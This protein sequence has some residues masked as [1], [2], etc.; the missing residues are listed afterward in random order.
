MGDPPTVLVVEDD[1]GLVELYREWLAGDYELR[2]ATDGATALELVDDAVDV[3][4]IDRQLSDI[5]GDEVLYAIRDRGYDCRTAMVTAVDPDF[6]VV[7]TELDDYLSEPVSETELC[8]TV[9]SLLAL[10]EY[11]DLRLELSTKRVRHSVLRAEKRRGELDDSE[12]FEQLE[13]EIARLERQLS[14]IE[15]EHPDYRPLFERVR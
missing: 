14:D 9:D 3:A 7:D 5:S 8:E 1:P 4:L 6:D 13:A 11:S 10:V 15:A 12:A 2:V